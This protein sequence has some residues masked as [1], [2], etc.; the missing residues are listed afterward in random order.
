MKKYIILLL[1]LLT[2]GIHVIFDVPDIICTII[3][4]CMLWVLPTLVKYIW[5][6]QKEKVCY[7]DNLWDAFL[8]IQ[9]A[10]MYIIAVKAFRFPEVI[11]DCIALPPFFVALIIAVKKA[12]KVFKDRRS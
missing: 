12:V 8:I 7:I 11:E 4:L 10:W 1:G 9:A 3:L 5:Y 6:L 2:I